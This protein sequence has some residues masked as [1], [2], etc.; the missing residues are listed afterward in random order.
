MTPLRSLTLRFTILAMLASR[1]P[2][3]EPSQP[4]LKTEHFDHDPGW[5]GYNNHMTATKAAIVKQDFGYSPTNFAG[6]AKGEMGGTIQRAGKPASYAAPLASAMTLEDKLSASG[7][8]AIPSR[9]GGGVFFGFFSSRHP[10]SRGL[11]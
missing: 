5:E 1:L 3:A 8:F 11:P 2:A 7:S 10:A 4:T 6:Q 9:S